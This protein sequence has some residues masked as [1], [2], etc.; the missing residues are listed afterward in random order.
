L[1]LPLA[2][3]QNLATQQMLVKPQITT[4]YCHAKMPTKKSAFKWQTNNLRINK[5]GVAPAR[6]ATYGLL[7]YQRG[8]YTHTPPSGR[9]KTQVVEEPISTMVRIS[10]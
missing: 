10:T 2:D 3:K 1:G 8:V 7:P 9:G 5:T 6:S 4:R